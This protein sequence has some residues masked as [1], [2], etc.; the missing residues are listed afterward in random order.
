MVI[1]GSNGSAPFNRYLVA[2]A[3]V[4]GCCIACDGSAAVSIMFCCKLHLSNR[5]RNS[6]S[7]AIDQ[8]EWTIRETPQTK[9]RAFACKFQ[10]IDNM[11]SLCDY[12]TICVYLKKKS[13]CNAIF[14]LKDFGLLLF[15]STVISICS[16]VIVYVVWLRAEGRSRNHMSVIF[17][18]VMYEFLFVDSNNPAQI[19][20]RLVI[21]ND[22]KDSS[23]VDH[24]PVE[25]VH[26]LISLMIIWCRC[27]EW[28][29]QLVLVHGSGGPN[30]WA[31]ID[32]KCI[33]QNEAWW[34]A[35]GSLG[36]AWVYSMSHFP[37]DDPGLRTK[38]HT[39]VYWYFR[40]PVSHLP[41]ILSKKW[42]E[43]ATPVFTKMLRQC[44]WWYR[45]R[46][47]SLV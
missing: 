3:T 25:C 32:C 11:S 46:G 42:S 34:W 18:Q 37:V 29:K 23:I 19:K 22:F 2:L 47:F 6:P 28:Y 13:N 33:P 35:W 9:H 41:L 27:H 39:K 12:W 14:W 16:C 31:C 10:L 15:I 44:N 38:W 17:R 40:I 5:S 7:A 30:A 24:S 20:F 26:A 45:E 1:D 4:C 21:R 36:S 8:R 43:W